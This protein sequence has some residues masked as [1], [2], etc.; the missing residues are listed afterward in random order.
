[1]RQKLKSERKHAALLDGR[2]CHVAAAIVGTA[3]VGA[4]MAPDAPDPNPGMQA[5][6]AA[7]ERVGMAQVELAKQQREDSL[8]R[9]AKLDALTEKV[10]NA[11]L[12][13]MQKNSALADEYADYNRTTFRPLEQSIVDAANN[14][15]TPAEQARAAGEAGADVQRAATGQRQ[16][17]GREMARMGVNP[18]SGRFQSANDSAAL[19]AAVAE[20]GAENS[21]RQKVRDLGFARK[22]DAASLGRGLPSSQATSAGIALNSGNSA[23]GNLATANSSANSAA[24]TTAGIYGGANASFGTSGSLS[25]MAA[26][27][28]AAI[29]GIQAKQ[30]SDM[31]GG[32]GSGIGMYYGMKKTA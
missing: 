15:D 31:M 26:Q 8:A 32:I 21:A 22:M 27:Q 30:H 9:N 2:Y 7:S 24:A 20:A 11:Q 13:S 3:V 23:V 17:L 12:D 19:G 18:N 6:A 4:V 29:Y 28:A 10:T 25:N 1:M 16:A 14:T 5:S